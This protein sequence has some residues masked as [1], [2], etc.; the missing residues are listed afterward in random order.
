MSY[1]FIKVSLNLLTT[2]SLF[3]LSAIFLQMFCLI[4]FLLYNPL[5]LIYPSRQRICPL[6]NLPL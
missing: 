2:P 3:L 1:T 4:T 6:L 5:A